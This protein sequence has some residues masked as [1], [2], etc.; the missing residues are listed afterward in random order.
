MVSFTKAVREALA[1]GDPSPLPPEER[2][3]LSWEAAVERL[4]D[5]A[6]VGETNT[7]WFMDQ[8]GSVGIGFLKQLGDFFQSAVTGPDSFGSF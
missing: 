1:A 5:A 2:Y 4:F 8:L 3:I 6:E 7:K